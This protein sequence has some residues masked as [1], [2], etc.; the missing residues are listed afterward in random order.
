MSR[1]TLFFVVAGALALVALIA[2]APLKGQAGAPTPAGAA[3]PAPHVAAA[4]PTNAVAPGQAGSLGLEARLSHPLVSADGQDVYAAID[5]TA[6]GAADMK[7]LPINLAL[8]IDRSGSMA[9]EKLRQ[10]KLAAHHLV[11]QLRDDDSLGIVHYGTD[12][13][14]LAGRRVTA[15]NREVLHAFIDDITEGG[16]TDIGAALGEGQAAL[17]AAR[18][19]YDVS[20]LI[21]ISDGQPNQGVTSLSGLSAIVGDLRRTGVS[22]SSIGVG[23]D[24]DEHIMEGLAEAGAGAYAFLEDAAQLDGI[25]QRDLAAA[26]TQVAQRAQLTFEVPAGV[27]L[28]AVLG[29]PEVPGGR[30]GRGAA[31]AVTVALPDFAA[32][33]K[34]RVVVRLR[35]PAG[36]AGERVPVT[37]LSLTWFDLPTSRDAR[38]TTELFALASDSQA[39]IASHRDPEA[40]VFA[41]RAQAAE[42][43]RKAAE[44]FKKG[45][46]D[47]ARAAYGA[48]Q[49][50]LDDAA[51]V[52]G[53]DALAEDKARYQA[54]QDRFESARSEGELKSAGKSARREA[55]IDFGLMSST[56]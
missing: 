1:T 33:Q 5:V 16:G 31:T 38:A 22:V 18:G 26:G 47:G 24:F 23:A 6:A 11:D 53:L 48:S 41:A 25:F 13:T 30:V 15:A 52:A 40:T 27:V 32:G 42:S 17:R 10:A 29:H 4:A 50:A 49:R 36:R 21:L 3:V 44:L 46:R 9:G 20:R 12:T 51:G 14:T 8:V 35:V 55:R 28:E 39:A 7:R 54:Q 45:D 37:G 56:Y 2:N 43:G 34:E 19:G